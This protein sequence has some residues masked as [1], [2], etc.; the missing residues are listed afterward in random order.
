MPTAIALNGGHRA[1]QSPI[2]S[3]WATGSRN[4]IIAPV[5]REHRTEA[6]VAAASS[7]RN[8]LEIIGSFHETPTAKVS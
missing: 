6:I 7:P 8:C 3:F 4:V 2:C 5:E 1:H